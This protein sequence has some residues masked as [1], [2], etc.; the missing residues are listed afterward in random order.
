MPSAQR[1]WD[2]AIKD[3]VGKFFELYITDYDKFLDCFVERSE[4]MKTY[5][6]MSVRDIMIGLEYHFIPDPDEPDEFEEEEA[7]MW[8][9]IWNPITRLRDKQRKENPHL[10]DNVYE[11]EKTAFI[12]Q[13]EKQIKKHPT[14]NMVIYSRKVCWCFSVESLWVYESLFGVKNEHLKRKIGELKDFIKIMKR[15]NTE[16]IREKMSYEKNKIIAPHL[17]QIIYDAKTKDDEFK[18]C[19]CLDKPSL[20]DYS[21]SKCGHDYC[22]E[23]IGKIETC[24]ICRDKL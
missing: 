14:I 13:F 20:D 8:K 23:C 9:S 5:M 19:I 11:A 6:I 16:L 15:V 17:K 3:L 7:N 4:D 2:K 10:M 22:K 24:S 21:V 12:I 1:V 18:C